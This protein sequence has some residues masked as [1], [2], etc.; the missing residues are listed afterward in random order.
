VLAFCAALRLWMRIEAMDEN[1]AIIDVSLLQTPNFR[2]AEYKFSFEGVFG[3]SFNLGLLKNLKFRNIQHQPPDHFDKSLVSLL[4]SA[5][6]PLTLSNGAL[7]FTRV[8]VLGGGR[9]TLFCFKQRREHQ[10]RC[11]YMHLKYSTL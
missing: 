6:F 2:F 11:N 9:I 4:G 7:R 1:S 10:I 3:W 5:L 8:A